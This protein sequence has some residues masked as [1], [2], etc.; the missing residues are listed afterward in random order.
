MLGVFRHDIE[1]EFLGTQL[2]VS[3]PGDVGVLTN[4]VFLFVFFLWLYVYL[5]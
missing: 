4:L 5:N 1:H 2:L 3:L